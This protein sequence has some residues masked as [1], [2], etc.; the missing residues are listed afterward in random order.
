MRFFQTGTDALS[1]AALGYA[2]LAGDFMAQTSSITYTIHCMVR[3]LDN[4]IIFLL[5][6][7]YTELGFKVAQHWFALATL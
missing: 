6:Y 5:L 4:N 1:I 3:Q 7:G 2:L